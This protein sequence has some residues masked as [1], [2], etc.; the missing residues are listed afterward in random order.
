MYNSFRSGHMTLC[1]KEIN[2]GIENELV[3][4]Q[5][6]RSGEC[7]ILSLTINSFIQSKTT[8][9]LIV[10]ET[11][12][13]NEIHK[14]NQRSKHNAMIQQAMHIYIKTAQYNTER[15]NSQHKYAI[16]RQDQCQHFLYNSNF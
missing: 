12:I 6:H 5:S 8:I 3:Y 11:S 2:T 14:V 4:T 10:L 15:K 13:G 9:L 16:P 7:S 1:S